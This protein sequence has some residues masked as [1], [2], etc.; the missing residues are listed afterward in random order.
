MY[1]RFPVTENEPLN[2]EK[3]A[4]VIAKQKGFFKG[5]FIVQM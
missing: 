4:A 5:A 2:L 1:I 3:N